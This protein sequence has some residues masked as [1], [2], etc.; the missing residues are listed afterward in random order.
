MPYPNPETINASGIADF[1]FCPESWRFARLGHESAN[2]PRRDAGSDHHA[3]K[4]KAERVA[5]GLIGLGSF[6]IALAVLA[7]TLIWFLSR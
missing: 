3:S 1:V 7:L 2:Q 4:A 6:L 5:G